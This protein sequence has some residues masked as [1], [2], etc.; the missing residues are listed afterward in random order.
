MDKPGRLSSTSALSG[1]HSRNR[2]GQNRQIHPEIL[3]FDVID[4]ELHLAREVNFTPAAN[5]PN[6]GDSR[7]HSQTPPV[8]GG[9]LF[10]LARHRWA[11][12][13]E[14]HVPDQDIVKL[15]QFVE[16]KLSKPL[17]G[18]GDAGII[19]DFESHTLLVA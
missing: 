14:G 7:C 1:K 5:L 6:A 8:G 16:G 13:D 17:A 15:R 3:S 12:A 2:A 11:G 18:S 19:L 10:D 4:I 9:V